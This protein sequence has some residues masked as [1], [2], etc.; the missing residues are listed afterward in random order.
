MTRFSADPILAGLTDFQR[1][2]VDHVCRQLQT[3]GGSGWFL[4]ADETGLGKSMVARGVI[5]KTVEMLETDDNIKRIDIVYVCAN[6]DLAQQN[7]TRLNVTP[8]EAVAFSSRLTLL[9]RHTAKLANTRRAGKPVNLVSF[10]P[11]T[12]FDM[13]HSN[14]AAPERAMLF[15]ILCQIFDLSKAQQTALKRILQ[16]QVRTLDGFSSTIYG[17]QAELERDGIDPVIVRTF[18]KEI[19]YG[20]RRLGGQLL[21]LIDAVTGRSTVPKSHVD[22]PAKM[23]RS[24]R[25]ALARASVESLEPDL[26]ILDEFQRFRHLLNEDSEAG[27]LAHDLFRHQAAKVLLLSA[28]PYKAFTYAE[29]MGEDHASDF[30]KT[31]GFLGEG[32]A[33]F[34]IQG[35]QGQLGNYRAAVTRGRDAGAITQAI[36]TELLKVMSRAERPQVE[37]VIGRKEVVRPAAAVT[38]ADLVGYGALSEVARAV[39]EPR[40]AGLVT[41]EY[42][43]SA[44]YFVNFCDTY[45]LGE[46]IKGATLSGTPVP[47]LTRTQRLRRERLESFTPIDGGNAKMRDLLAHTVDKGWWKLLWIPPSMPY[48]EPGGPYAG[49]EGVTKMLVFSSWTATPT[50]V[51]SILSYEAERRAAEGSGY[52]SYTAE[53]RRR[54]TRPLSYSVRDGVPAEMTTMLVSWP[55]PGLAEAAD[56]LALVAAN[57]GR[58][59]NLADAVTAAGRRV[60]D[61]FGQAPSHS[62]SRAT[63]ADGHESLWRVVFSHVSAWPDSHP[64]TES[65]HMYVNAMSG[66]SVGSEDDDGGSPQD[67]GQWAHVEAA[68]AALQAGALSLEPEQVE[69]L[70]RIAL[71]SPANIAYRALSRV[72]TDADAVEQAT[73]F[74][75]AAVIGNGL[76]SLFNRPDVAKLIEKV[77]DDDQAF[78][79]RVLQYCAWGNLQATMDEFVHHL[80]QDQFSSPLTEWTLLDLADTVAASISLRASTYQALN[81]DDVG[82]PLTFA[83]K[84]ALRY[85]GRK[86]ES[87]DARQPEVRRAFNGPFWPFVLAS[88][89]VG[90]EGI[91]FHWWSHSVFHWNVPPNPVD[92]EQREGRVDR[93]RGHAI[94]RNVA[95]KH[96]QAVLAD[97]GRDPWQRAFELATDLTET[98]G[99][100]TPNWVYPGPAQIERHVAPFALSSDQG[101][102]EQTKKDVALYRLTFGQPRQEDMITLLRQRGEVGGVYSH[103]DYRI[104]LTPPEADALP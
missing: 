63:G 78:W 104:N 95:H 15:L 82:A 16:G 40:D 53:S 58:P 98:Y 18:K 94:R 44:P 33:D 68:K 72:L 57:G 49:V 23:V 26:V 22:E 88:T 35:L 71:H 97:P 83:P 74:E 70:A 89:S 60:V 2:T 36:S 93:Y 96:A 48:F 76:R 46:R 30:L 32:H 25:R 11:G 14:G 91:D 51:A 73:H 42:W 69:M 41:A 21:E 27:E 77:T 80:R 7:I 17:L 54:Q 62:R 52:S 87:E 45:K 9:A 75:A 64:D 103:S 43:K 31:V 59:L 8:D 86:N 101:R 3:P 61:V 29:E 55:M 6:A 85:G 92:F 12:S 28:T 34:D 24:L 39:K 102:Y 38:A 19:G 4:V 100:F 90:Q 99:D 65:L 56:P 79:Q 66:H 20:Q 67:A 50:A 84:F 81:A 13:G 47:A 10:T 37:D 5:A 1:R